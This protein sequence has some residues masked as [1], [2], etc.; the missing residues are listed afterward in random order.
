MRSSWTGWVALALF[1]VSAAIGVAC[2]NTAGQC[3]LTAECTGAPG[4]N[5]GDCDPNASE[6]P[7]PETCGTFAR[8][9]ADPDISDGSPDRPFTTLT[10]AVQVAVDSGAHI[11]YACTGTFVENV[12]L[13]PDFIVYGGLDCENQWAPDPDARTT[14]APA[15]GIAVTFQPGGK[16]TVQNIRAEAPDGSPADPGNVAPSGGSSIAALAEQGAT[17]ELERCDFVAG[18]GAPGASIPTPE[19]GMPAQDGVRGQNACVENGM[20]G[21]GGVFVCTQSTAGGNGGDGGDTVLQD[22]K[23]GVPGNPTGPGGDSGKGQVGGAMCDAGQPGDPGVAGAAGTGGARPAAL[24]DLKTLL[25]V[26]GTDGKAGADGG[27]GGGGGG[28]KVCMANMFKG[29]SGGGG[30]AGG[31]GGAAGKGGGAG[32]SSIAFWAIEATVTFNQCTLSTKDGG[33]GAAGAAG[34]KGSLGGL[35]GNAGMPGPAGMPGEDS[36]ACPGGKGGDGGDGGPGGGG[37]GGSSI[38]IVWKMIP[39]IFKES[40]ITIGMLGQGGPGGAALP[41]TLAGDP[42]LA[43]ASYDANAS[44]CAPN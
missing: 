28:G 29:A 40:P 6:G 27:G 10:K 23:S 5:P 31:C 36:I 9:D 19:Q 41:A 15:T 4:I 39:P 38:G 18:A 13:P 25:G 11:V 12:A 16:T 37:S 30:G 14:I 7:I 26:A 32:G 34:Q 17:V 42:G 33:A 24:I 1:A 20:G 8:A 22:G 3:E 43:C 21:E 35:G 2:E 44:A